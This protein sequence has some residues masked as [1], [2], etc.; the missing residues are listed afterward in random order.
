[1]GVEAGYLVSMIRERF[2]VGCDRNG[3]EFAMAFSFAEKMESYMKK[4]LFYYV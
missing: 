4:D 1:M 2:E 3:D